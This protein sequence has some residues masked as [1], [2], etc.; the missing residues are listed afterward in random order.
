MP[1]HG[2]IMP[3]LCDLGLQFGIVAQPHFVFVSD[4]TISHGEV[5]KFRVYMQFREQGFSLVVTL[6]HLIKTHRFNFSD[7]VCSEGLRYRAPSTLFST[8]FL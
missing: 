6:S 4:N 2:A 3:G 1:T 7:D 8:P 5:F